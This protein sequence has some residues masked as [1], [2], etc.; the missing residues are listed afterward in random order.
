MSRMKEYWVYVQEGGNPD[1]FVGP[2]NGPFGRHRA[3]SK[4]RENGGHGHVLQSTREGVPLVEIARQR[5]EMERAITIEPDP[6]TTTQNP[7]TAI[8]AAQAAPTPKPAT[9]SRIPNSAMQTQNPIAVRPSPSTVTIPLIPHRR[10][11][12]MGALRGSTSKILTLEEVRDYLRRLDRLQ[13]PVDIERPLCDLH[14]GFTEEG[15]RVTACWKDKPQEKFLLTEHG[16]SNLC[17]QV[18]P[19]HGKNFLLA[20]SGLGEQG[21]KIATVAYNEHARKQKNPRMVRFVNTRDPQSGQ[22]RRAI[23]SSHSQSYATYSHLDYVQ[24]MLDHSPELASMS[25]LQFQLD[26]ASM[27]LRVSATPK[28]EMELNTPVPMIECWNSETGQRTVRFTSGIW[29]LVCLN[30]MGHWSDEAAWKW[31][32]YGDVNRIYRGVDSALTSVKMHAN[33]LIEAYNTALET[34]VDDIFGF[35]EAELAKPLGTGRLEAAKVALRDPTTTPGN[36]LASVV[37]SI[38]LIAQDESSLIQAEEL[39]RTASRLLQRGLL[40]RRSGRIVAEA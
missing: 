4:R 33:G 13:A 1:T 29:K 39:E 27:R 38:T 21:K 32:H 30:G 25:V 15:G 17:T 14:I 9:M 19:S 23:R 8:S 34:A 7:N 11:A 10:L 16:F 20:T 37:D 2:W 3:E 31:R 18:L 22:V 6:R 40:M 24:G 36:T 26:D 12:D 28:N 5:E 35:M